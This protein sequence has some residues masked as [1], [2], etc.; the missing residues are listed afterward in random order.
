VKRYSSRLMNV[1]E[2]EQLRPATGVRSMLWM[3]CQRYGALAD[4]V[5][6]EILC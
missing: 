4:A 6:S 5:F 1:A 3:N 2:V